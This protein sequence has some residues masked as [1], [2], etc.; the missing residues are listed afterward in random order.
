MI[1]FFKK[2]NKSI[3]IRHKE[4]FINPQSSWVKL[5]QF[6][7]VLG[8]ILIAFSFYILFLIKNDNGFH[9]EPDKSDN[10]PSLIEEDLLDRVNESI[11]RKEINN[12]NIESGNIK[13]KDPS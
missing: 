12:K 6:F 9:V 7:L 1:K 5:V 10:P 4:N 2:T 3:K 8:F 13:F 11:N